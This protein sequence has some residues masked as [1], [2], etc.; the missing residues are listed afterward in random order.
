MSD[1]IS[2]SSSTSSA[3]YPPTQTSSPFSTS[4]PKDIVDISVSETSKTSTPPQNRPYGPRRISDTFRYDI[5]HGMFD[6]RLRYN[7]LSVRFQDVAVS[8]Y[9]AR[10][11]ISGQI[12]S[13][14]G[15]N[16]SASALFS[17]IYQDAQPNPNQASSHINARTEQNRR[18]DRGMDLLNM[19]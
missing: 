3:Y 4:T 7:A 6:A 5:E 19:L 11:S 1:A 18:I 15:Q 10:Q 16:S 13:F 14:S 9:E 8:T 12:A 17:L 2:P